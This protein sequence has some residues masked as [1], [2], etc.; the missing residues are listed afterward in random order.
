MSFNNLIIILIYISIFLTYINTYIIIP[1][2]STD[3]LYF[4]ALSESEL[5]INNNEKNSEIFSKYINNVL[6]TDLVVGEPNQK[7]TAFLSQDEYGF[8]FYEE[9]STKELKELGS[10]NYNFYLKNLSKTISHTDGYN[11]EHSF[12]SYLSHEDFLYLYKYN[13]KD[14]FSIEELYNKKITKTENKIHFIYTIR[15]SSKIPNETD[16]IKIQKNFEKEQDELRKLNFTNFSYFSIGLKFGNKNSAGITK[17]FIEEFFTKKEITNKKWNI[18][19]S[20]NKDHNNKNN[21]KYNIFLIIGSLPH[22]Y[23]SNIFNE[24]E[25]FCTYSEKSIFSDKPTLSFYDIY[26]NINNN[27][28]SLTK[29][30]RTTE[31][32]FNFGL[33]SASWYA[34]NIL[35][36]K[37]FNN[38]IQQGK[39]FESR[40]NKTGYS[41]YV[42]F[43]CDK[44]KITKEEI[45]KFPGIY[46]KH[47][48][49]SYIFEF[50][51][52]DLFEN[53]G[54]IIIF[55][56]I[57][58]SSNKW[59]LGK[60]FLTK[61]ML[62]FD[63]E[64]KKIYFYNKNYDD[65]NHDNNNDKNKYSTI[66]I[67][68]I[69]FG[70]FLF[71]ILGFFIGKYFYKKE[72]IIT[73]ELEDIE[74]GNSVVNENKDYDFNQEKLI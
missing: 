32:N 50:N 8:N 10:K 68:P 41:Y 72:K 11:Y 16:F 29:F 48:E 58:D 51:S 55:K 12:W 64:D 27:T 46:F 13:D 35:E 38:L 54:D 3:E 21:N 53:F 63:D 52:D 39:C 60:L 30:D 26:T 34:K 25:Q 31:I 40:I 23:F 33:I 65:N 18:Y 70:V 47:T 14:I 7:A 20:K 66:L 67:I 61:Y 62:S 24:I 56:M 15:N 71:G 43:Y 1:L 74:E 45:K 57:F 49:F 36:K 2:K 9:F 6:Y 22:I 42:Y 28:I 4:S 17:S 19:Y 44:N 59:V 5:S 73:H 69:I 37:Y